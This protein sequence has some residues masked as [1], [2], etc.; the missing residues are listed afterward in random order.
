MPAKS[1]MITSDIS[2]SDKLAS[3]SPESLVL[4]FFL[5]PYFS[6]H[7]K[8]NG[9]PEYIKGEIVPKIKWLTVQKIT[10]C[11]EEINEKT[12]VK[13]FVFNGLYWLHSLN[14]KEHQ[15]GLRRM[16]KDHFPDYSGSSVGASPPDIDI[17]LDIDTDK[18]P[19]TPKG[20][21]ESKFLLFWQN[22]PK[23]KA[24]GDAL[25]AWIKLNPDNSTVKEILNAIENQK[26]SDDWKKEGGQF[27]PY[28]ASWLN[29]RRWEDE[30]KEPEKP[31]Q[32]D[33]MQGIVNV[34]GKSNE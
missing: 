23:K 22:Y 14:Y 34:K 32:P 4:F 8:M 25:K 24:K 7:G 19:P 26:Q 3:L 15:P 21:L 27:I 10:K 20:E 31:K 30:I 5:L 12:N 2:V 18:T 17:D 9:R 1:R 6:V 28:P 11:L 16:G 13:W 33:Y 29:G